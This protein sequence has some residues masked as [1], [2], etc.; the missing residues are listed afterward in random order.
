MVSLELLAPGV[1]HPK[2]YLNNSIA[3]HQAGMSAILLSSFSCA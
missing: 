2:L 3:L 1:F